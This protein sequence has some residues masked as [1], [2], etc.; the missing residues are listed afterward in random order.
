MVSVLI[1]GWWNFEDVNLVG[2]FFSMI[3][4]N[5]AFRKFQMS[6]TLS[7]GENF[8][9]KAVLSARTSSLSLETSTLFQSWILRLVGF[10]RKA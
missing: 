9:R 7:D 8:S 3:F 10:L 4:E 5:S 2:T 1:Q 6:E